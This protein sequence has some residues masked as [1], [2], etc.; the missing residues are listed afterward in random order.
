MLGKSL[1]HVLLLIITKKPRIKF[2]LWLSL[3]KSILNNHCKFS[4]EKYKIYESSIK[5]ALGS[6]MTLI[7]VFKNTK[8]N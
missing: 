7:P 3:M 4:K 8:L 2:I 1:T 5:M 6:E